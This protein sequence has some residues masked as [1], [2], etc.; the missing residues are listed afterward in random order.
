MD[1][2]KEQLTRE[3]RAFPTLDIADTVKSV[4]GCTFAD[5]TLNDYKPH[6]KIEMKMA[7]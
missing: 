2:L 7:V 1:A 4:E 5:L 6:G 3:P